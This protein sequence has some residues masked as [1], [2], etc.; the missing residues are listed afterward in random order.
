MQIYLS[1]E[2][3]HI[4]IKRMS[5]RVEF[6][7]TRGSMPTPYHPLELQHQIHEILNTYTHSIFAPKQDVD[8]FMASLPQH[9]KGGYGGN[10]SCVSVK[11]PQAQLFIDGGTGI[12]HAVGPL[13]KG[14]CAHGKGE[15]HILMTH[16]HWDHIMGIP[17][18]VP[19][20]IPGNQIHFYGVQDDLEAMVETLFRKP[21]F[22]VPFSAIASN[23]R[24]H[25]IA[26]RTPFHIGDMTIS[27]YQL[28][29]P[30][31]CWGYRVECGGK[32]Y[33][34]CVD[35]EGTRVSRKDLGPDLPLY[36]GV[37]LMYFD[38]QYTVEEL[39]EKINW[40]HSSV[41]V[42]LQIAL[43]EQVRIV[44]FAHHDPY[45][46]DDD[47]SRKM[48]DAVQHY[49]DMLRLSPDAEAFFNLEWHIG[50]EGMSFDL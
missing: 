31:P 33:S 42:G 15:V 36:Q 37:D 3:L 23:V 35:T 50:I 34:H 19:I 10:T 38:G 30:D 20:F 40:G 17:F 39:K 16:F 6:L 46:T 47:L 2:F 5:L 48:N 27:A 49:D 21:F 8:G 11:S 12:R 25:K 14:D 24:F 22:P 13:M 26:P 45:A 32:V 4:K 44:V 9:I 43:R 41:A 29:H 18:F 28:D 7:G 1:G